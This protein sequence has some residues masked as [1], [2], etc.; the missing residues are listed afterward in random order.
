MIAPSP[1]TAALFSC[2]VGGRV[3]ASLPEVWWPPSLTDLGA[4]YGASVDFKGAMDALHGPD[5]RPDVILDLSLKGDLTY[6]GAAWKTGRDDDAPRSVPTL[7]PNADAARCL[8]KARA[9]LATFGCLCPP[10]LR[11]SS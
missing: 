9:D 11:S 4:L 7:R 2:A 6:Y 5:T 1:P 8:L 3:E 10:P